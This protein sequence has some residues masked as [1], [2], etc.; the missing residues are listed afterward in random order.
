MSNYVLYYLLQCLLFISFRCN[1]IIL[2]VLLLFA[3]FVYCLFYSERSIIMFR[4]LFIVGETG[5]DRFS[6]PT[7][8]NGPSIGFV[9]I[10]IKSKPSSFWAQYTPPP[11]PLVRGEDALA[12]GEGVGVNILEDARHTS[13]LYICKYR[14]CTSLANLEKAHTLIFISTILLF[15]TYLIKNTN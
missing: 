13:V 6:G 11:P 5:T 12:R 4:V 1:I 7:H 15:N 3:A 8:S 2:S 10:K 14:Q 9:L